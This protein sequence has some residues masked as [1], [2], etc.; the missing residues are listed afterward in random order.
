MSILISS[1]VCNTED[2]FRS[3]AQKLRLCLNCQ[4]VAFCG[5][6]WFSSPNQH[7]AALF[8]SVHPSFIRKPERVCIWGLSGG[9]CT[10][11]SCHCV[12]WH[13]AM[14]CQTW[15]ALMAPPVWTYLM[16]LR[17]QSHGIFLLCQCARIHSQA[18][19]KLT[20]ATVIGLKNRQKADLWAAHQ[21]KCQ[22]F[23]DFS[24]LFYSSLYKNN[25]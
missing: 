21:R 14:C 25:F 2:D 7:I 8:C 20:Y 22:I 17:S 23:F 11:E 12:G 1:Q 6:V 13:V 4:V 15:E 24:K 18:L 3:M 19:L 5:L 16:C 10:P 9:G